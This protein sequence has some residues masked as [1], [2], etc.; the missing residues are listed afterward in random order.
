MVVSEF[1]KDKLQC[2]SAYQTITSITFVYV[3][4]SVNVVEEYI[5]VWILEGAIHWG[6]G[7]SNLLQNYYVN[8]VL[9]FCIPLQVYQVYSIKYTW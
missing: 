5:R 3:E 4:H 7:C 9:F 6:P 2:A 8:A 1:Q